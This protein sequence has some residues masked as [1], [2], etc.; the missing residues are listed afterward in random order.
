MRFPRGI[1]PRVLFGN[2]DRRRVPGEEFMIVF[3]DE[4]FLDHDTFC[5]GILLPLFKF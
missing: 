4:M 1:M 5:R 2:G 3:H